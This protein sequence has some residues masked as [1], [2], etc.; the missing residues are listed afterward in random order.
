VCALNQITNAKPVVSHAISWLYHAANYKQ[1][2][3][4]FFL[5]SS[6]L[7]TNILIRTFFGN[8]STGYFSFKLRD[9]VS[10]PFKITGKY[11]LSYKLINVSI[12]DA[13]IKKPEQNGRKQYTNSIHS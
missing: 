4:A 2:P 3:S 12:A 7:G 11:I 6:F 8:I 5:S 13:K 9:E 1:L 10:Y